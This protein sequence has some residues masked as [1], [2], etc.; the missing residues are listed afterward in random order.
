MRTLKS[1]TVSCSC[2]TNLVCRFI[3]AS[4]MILRIAATP[5]AC[6]IEECVL[7]AFIVYW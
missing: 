1:P 6:S 2:L 5:A 4:N 3:L 7:W